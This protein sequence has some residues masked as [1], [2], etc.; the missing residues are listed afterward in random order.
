MRNGTALPGLQ[1]QAASLTHVLIRLTLPLLWPEGQHSS[2]PRYWCVGGAEQ[3]S[4]AL[5]APRWRAIGTAL[6]CSQVWGWL[7]HTCTN[8]VDSIVLPWQD[9]GPAIPSLV[10][11]GGLLLSWPQGQLFLPPQ[12][13]M[14][15]RRVIFKQ[16]NLSKIIL[17]N[18][19]QGSKE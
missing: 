4:P 2:C 8:R 5:A 17:A 6:L 19:I 10:A 14:G 9:A 16:V 18:W 1:F 15:R 13:L 3:L 7:S 11:D 12:A